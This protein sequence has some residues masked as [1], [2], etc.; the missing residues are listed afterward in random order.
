MNDMTIHSSRIHDGLVRLAGGWWLVLI[1]CERKILLASWWLVVDAEIM[2]EKNTA[3]W[4]TASQPNKVEMCGWLKLSD[5]PRSVQVQPPFFAEQGW[6]QGRR[7]SSSPCFSLFLFLRPC[8][9]P[10]IHPKFYYAKR[11]FPI[12]SKYRHMHGVLNVDE[13]KN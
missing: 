13:I 11:R 8:L 3:G 6:E 2:W 9:V 4:L 1:C 5:P 10:Q 12:T 7:I